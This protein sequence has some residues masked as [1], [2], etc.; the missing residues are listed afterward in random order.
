MDMNVVKHVCAAIGEQ[1]QASQ[2]WGSKTTCPLELRR[3]MLERMFA[4]PSTLAALMIFCLE[5]CIL[6]Y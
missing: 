3:V 5:E 6:K 4:E 1:I 2:Y